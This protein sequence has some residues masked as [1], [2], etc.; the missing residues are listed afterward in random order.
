MN[1]QTIFELAKNFVLNSP[2]NVVCDEKIKDLRLFETPLMGVANAFDP[3][4]EKLK[5]PGAIGPHFGPPEAWLPGAKSV[6]SFFLPFTERVRKANAESF[7]LP[8]YE[9]LCGRVE[10]Q[11]FLNE[12]SAYLVREIIASGANA[13]SPYIDPRFWT[14]DPPFAPD[15]PSFTS[16]WSE[17]HIGFIAGL[18]TFGLS[19]GFISEKGMAGRMCSVVTDLPLDPDLRKYSDI[20]EYCTMCGACIR[21]CPAGAISKETGKDHAACKAYFV[22]IRVHCSPRYGCGKCQTTVPCETSAPGLKTVR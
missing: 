3:Y 18:G 16:N 21:R 20:Y 1:R 4:F 12:L 15:S 13:V 19:K 22:S 6:I 7:P 14:T 10:G 5:E 9:W 11:A 2:L 17:R 8:A